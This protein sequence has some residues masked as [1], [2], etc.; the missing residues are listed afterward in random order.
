MITNERQYRIT[1]SWLDRFEQAHAHVAA[2]GTTLPPRAQQ[3]FRDQY[4][5]QIEELRAQLAEYEALRRGEVELLELSS[6]NELPEALIRARTAAKLSQVALAERLGVKKQQIQRWETTR[7]AGVD[8]ARLQAVADALGVRIREQVMLPAAT[9]ES[10]VLSP[11][12]QAD[13]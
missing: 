9:G 11:A 8:L 12:E 13:D 5:S 1:R 3:A 7:Y 6:L 10:E 2:Q 4:G